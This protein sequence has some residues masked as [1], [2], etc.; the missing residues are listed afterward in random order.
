MKATIAFILIFILAGVSYYAFAQSR[1]PKD[2]GPKPPEN[3]EP[4]V[5]DP[6]NPGY[7]T[8]GEF[9]IQCA[10]GSPVCEPGRP[11]YDT[12]GNLTPYCGAPCDPN[13]PAY[14]VNGNFNILCGGGARVS[15][16]NQ[17]LMMLRRGY[18]SQ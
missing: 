16:R 1:P 18:N 13:N 9:T 2:L 11:G 5:C 3:P 12:A 4:V 10:G 14:D 8:S 6:K 15:T 17:Q 7:T